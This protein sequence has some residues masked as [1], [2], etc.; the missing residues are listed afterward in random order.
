[1]EIWRIM[2]QLKVSIKIKYFKVFKTNKNKIRFNI[3]NQ[4]RQVASKNSQAKYTLAKVNMKN[5]NFKYLM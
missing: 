5:R 4:H 2:Q 1:M 3:R